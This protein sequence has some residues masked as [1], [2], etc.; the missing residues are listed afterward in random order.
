M[1]ADSPHRSAANVDPDDEAGRI[2]VGVDGSAE[3]R[4]ALQ[5]AVAM[6]RTFDCA[7][8]AVMVWQPPLAFEFNMTTVI[9]DWDPQTET[10]KHLGEFVDEVFGA[11]RPPRLRL[12][13]LE[14]AP[15][16]R[17][18]DRS[19]GAR[20]LVIGTRGHSSLTALALGSVSLRTLEHAHCPVLVVRESDR[21]P[22]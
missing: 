18:V 15:A 7:V 14:G 11:H 22:D 2:V 3:S 17:L 16:R 1:P 4:R 21:V 12:S 9:R 13:A 8:E 10:T 20:L 5:W 6:A 19:R